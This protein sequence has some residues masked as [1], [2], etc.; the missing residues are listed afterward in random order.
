MKAA[1]VK[2][3]DRLGVVERGDVAMSAAR[4]RFIEA[5]RQI[6]SCFDENENE[7]FTYKVVGDACDAFSDSECNDDCWNQLS[8]GTH[9]A[10]RAALRKEVL[11]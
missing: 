1:D 11:V 9:D 3:L 4:D 10:C 7:D 8:G 2:A 5:M 6:Q